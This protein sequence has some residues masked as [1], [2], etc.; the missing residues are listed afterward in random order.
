MG[1]DIGTLEIIRL[2]LSASLQE[3]VWLELLGKIMVQVES[4]MRSTTIRSEVVQRAEG[5]HPRRRVQQEQ[6][7]R[8]HVLPR[9]QRR[10]CRRSCDL[11][12]QHFFIGNDK[13]IQRMRALLLSKYEE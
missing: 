2:Y 7:R 5:D 11:H 12:W 4:H 10:A 1:R 3:D 6:L 8:V 13:E 9:P